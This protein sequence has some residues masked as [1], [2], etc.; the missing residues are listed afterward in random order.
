V[1]VLRG[2]DAALGPITVD[3]ATSDL[4]GQWIGLPGGFGNADFPGER[5]GESLAIPILRP[6]RSQCQD[7][8]CDLSKS[9]ARVTLGTATT[10]VSIKGDY[11]RW[12]R[13]LTLR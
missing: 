12:R 5:N 7:L 11:A 6:E 13:R 2:N 10:T 1:T 8:P 3:Y 4:T 9:H